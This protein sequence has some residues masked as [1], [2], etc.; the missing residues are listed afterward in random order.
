M[1]VIEGDQKAPFST[2]TTLRCRGGDTP[3]PRL[4]HF[5]LDTYLIL[6]RYQVPFFWVFGMMQPGIELRYPRPLANTLHTGLSAIVFTFTVVSTMYEIL[7]FPR[8]FQHML[9]VHNIIKK[10]LNF[11]TKFSDKRIF[12]E[13]ALQ[14]WQWLF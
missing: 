11:L 3:F 6:L 14:F 9:Y 5:T 7:V 1:T 2:A 8:S 10:F 12:S 4:L 13:Y